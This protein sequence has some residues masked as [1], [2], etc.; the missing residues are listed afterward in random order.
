[1]IN[2]FMLQLESAKFLQ[3]LTLREGTLIVAMAQFFLGISWLLQQPVNT[4]KTDA[5][6]H[7]LIENALWTPFVIFCIANGVTFVIAGIKEKPTLLLACL[8]WSFINFFISFIYQI[9][10]FVKIADFPD[11]GGDFGTIMNFTKAYQSLRFIITIAWCGFQ[12]F[13]GICV[14]TRK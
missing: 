9:L 3:L 13:F 2:L 7:T 12:A 5:I 4:E 14:I 10:G 8:V 6:T 1:M 11:V